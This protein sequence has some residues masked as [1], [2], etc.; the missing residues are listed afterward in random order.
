VLQ[1]HF[2]LISPTKPKNIKVIWPEWKESGIPWIPLHLPSGEPILEVNRCDSKGKKSTKGDHWR[3][4]EYRAG[5]RA[6]PK[7]D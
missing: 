3:I 1:L 7:P 5:H 6:N 4:V 2:V